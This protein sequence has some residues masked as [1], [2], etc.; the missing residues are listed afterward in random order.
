M[1]VCKQKYQEIPNISKRAE[2][3]KWSVERSKYR[4]VRGVGVERRGKQ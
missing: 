3:S 2:D 4:L 1:T